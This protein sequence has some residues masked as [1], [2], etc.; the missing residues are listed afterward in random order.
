MYPIL[1]YINR[2]CYP[3]TAVVMQGTIDLADL[4]ENSLTHLDSKHLFGLKGWSA[5]EALHWKGFCL[6]QGLLGQHGWLLSVTVFV[7]C[8]LSATTTGGDKLDS[9]EILGWLVTRMLPVLYD[10]VDV[11]HA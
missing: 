2:T 10:M 4:I 8:D 1:D 9:S 3:M 11:A 7:L 6:P 5:Y